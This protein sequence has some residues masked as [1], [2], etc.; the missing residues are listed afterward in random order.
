MSVTRQ[1]DPS[2]STG[3]N[4]ATPYPMYCCN[5]AICSG[6][7]FGCSMLTPGNDQ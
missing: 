6:V 3:P 1:P 5:S 7:N 4:H 2:T